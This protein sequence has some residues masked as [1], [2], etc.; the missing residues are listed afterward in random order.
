MNGVGKGGEEEV[1]PAGET[2]KKE[3]PGGGKK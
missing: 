1:F 3:R 2:R